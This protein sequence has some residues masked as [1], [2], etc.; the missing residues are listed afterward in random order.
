MNECAVC[1]AESEELNAKIDELEATG[2]VDKK[3]IKLLK[4]AMED[5]EKNHQD[6]IEEYKKEIKD[7]R[8]MID[9]LRQRYLG[10]VCFG[11]FCFVKVKY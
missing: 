6:N 3:E 1:F 7:L 8:K 5:L 10:F 11:N 4:D 9:K 2:K